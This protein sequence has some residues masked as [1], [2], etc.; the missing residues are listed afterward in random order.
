MPALTDD[1]IQ[2]LHVDDEVSLLD[3]TRECLEQSSDRLTVV[4][5]TTATAG[6][7]VLGESP[8]DCVLSDYDMPGMD[9]LAF[10]DRVR[11][12]Y[13]DLPFI[14]YTGKGSEEIASDAISAGVTDYLQKQSGVDHYDVLANKIETAVAR[15]RAERELRRTR[16]QYQRLVE[17]ELVG[18]YLIQNGAFQFVNEKL[19]AIHG[20]DREAVVGMSPL[21]LVSASDRDRV[22]RRLQEQLCGDREECHYRITGKHRDGSTLDLELHGGR[23]RYEGR[24]AVMGVV[25]NWSER[26]GGGE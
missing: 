6:L 11:A 12:R 22:G 16:E 24:P 25:M 9:G 4:H 17:Q 8:V 5:E 3:L 1:R 21:K 14:L 19:A 23:I 2:V 13:D 20:Y 18:I 26:D 7:D 15:H 10:L